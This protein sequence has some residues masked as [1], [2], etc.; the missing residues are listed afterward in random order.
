MQ[1]GGGSGEV[2][3]VEPGELPTLVRK[4]LAAFPCPAGIALVI[5]PERDEVVAALCESTIEHVQFSRVRNRDQVDR[6]LV[7]ST[8]HLERTPSI[9]H[10]ESLHTTRANHES[11][12]R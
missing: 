5:D 7:D 3:S 9:V 8:N 10:I 11:R 4:R 1:V 6:N 2:V 12:P